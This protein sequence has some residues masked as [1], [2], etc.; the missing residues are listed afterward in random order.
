MSANWAIVVGIA[1]A[2]VARATP[3]PEADALDV[4][5][6]VRGSVQPEAVS[7]QSDASL[8]PVAMAPA[9]SGSA[10]GVVM[11][12]KTL[13][14]S[15]ATKLSVPVQLVL[16]WPTAAESLFLSIGPTT[17]GR[18]RLRVVDPT[19][20]ASF[21]V[22][23]LDAIDSL[24][25]DTASVLQ[26]YV[27]A[28]RFHRYW[29]F[30][31]ASPNHE[32]A[33]RSARIWFDAQTALVKRQPNVFSTDPELASALDQYRRDSRTDP[34]VRRRFLRYFPTGLVTAANRQV[35]AAPFSAVA[36]V[37]KLIDL[38]RYD[39][40][41]QVNA[42]AMDALTGGDDQLR[43]AVLAT[44][45]VNTALLENNDRYLKS[46]L[47]NEPRNETTPP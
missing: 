4:Q 28:R 7:L 16:D 30:K 40:A 8:D 19:R 1:L 12:R 22:S 10:Y 47:E 42:A 18:I 25:Q 24:N 37:P 29:R 38:G 6:E 26:R 21:D 13:L 23:A 11:D 39:E 33:I 44:Q 31:K 9:A 5:V 15:G 41:L 35:I 36:E 43:A 17:P 14:P 2:S 27:M 45:G 20:P 3:A 34:D 46:L 32:I